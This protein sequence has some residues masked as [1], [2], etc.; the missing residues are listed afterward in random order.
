MAKWSYLIQGLNPSRK[1]L[2]GFII[3]KNADEAK[4]EFRKRAKPQTIV[5]FITVDREDRITRFVPRD[6][7]PIRLGLK[8]RIRKIKSKRKAQKTKK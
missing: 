5:K 7:G 4:E 3:A 8:A 1:I 2:T 6:L